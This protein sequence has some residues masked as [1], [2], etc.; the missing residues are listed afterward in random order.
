MNT[1][2]KRL[3]AL[4]RFNVISTVAGIGVTVGAFILSVLFG[5]APFTTGIEIAGWVFVITFCGIVALRLAIFL[6]K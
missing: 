2:D 1:D 3:T 5:A 6:R 4:R